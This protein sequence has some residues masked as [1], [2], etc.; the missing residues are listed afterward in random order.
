MTSLLCFLYVPVLA[1]AQDSTRIGS[2]NDIQNLP[3]FTVQSKRLTPNDIIDSI[4]YYEPKNYSYPP[5]YFGEI[6]CR[7]E[8]D[9]D[10]LF[11][12]TTDSVYFVRSKRR[13]A[14]YN[15]QICRQNK[16]TI[17]SRNMQQNDLLR[18]MEFNGF[19]PMVSLGTFLTDLR[20]V[21]SRN[22]VQYGTSRKNDKLL[23]HVVIK[24][25]MEAKDETGRILHMVVDRN[26]WKLMEIEHNIFSRQDNIVESIYSAPTCAET[27]ERLQIG[28]KRVGVACMEWALRFDFD[29]SQ[30][31][32]PFEFKV[33]DN[34]LFL[35]RNVLSNKQKKSESKYTYQIK[36]QGNLTEGPEC[37]S[38]AFS[39]TEW[40]H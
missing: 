16:S 15:A 22:E 24:Y 33:S 23:F 8:S 2:L 40:V 29:S 1:L 9:S 13:P 18:I 5:V 36:F 19:P 6:S 21:F 30:M 39:I 37:S 11:H 35:S 26:N 25:S 3:E 32:T 7:L 28:K 17:D 31:L 12:A 14:R 20:K 34:L 27:I 4:L 10:I 38:E